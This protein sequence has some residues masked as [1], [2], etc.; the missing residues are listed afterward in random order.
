MHDVRH[1]S[2]SIARTPS[3]VY[4]FA[5]DPARLPLWAEGLARSEVRRE[6]Q[7]WVA[8]A[9]FGKVRIRFAE[10]NAFGVLDHEVKLESGTR[11]HNPVRVVPNGDGS[12]FVFTLLRQPGMSDEQFEAD[13]AAVEA[14]L[15]RLKALLEQ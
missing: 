6:G 1:L 7:A 4:A 2:I 13:A 5:S 9:P 8:E 15:K 11:V 10:P 3:D 12:E 14:D